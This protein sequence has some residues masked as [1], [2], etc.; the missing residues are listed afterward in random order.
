MAA[1]ARATMYEA[2]EGEPV[3]VI[4][5]GD[6]RGRRAVELTDQKA[7]GSTVAKQAASPSPGFQPSAAA[8]SA[9]SA[10]SPGRIARMRKLSSSV[11]V[12]AFS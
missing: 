6:G 5:A 7:R 11:S 9:A 12:L 8:Q 3:V 2:E 10:I 4:D 1:A